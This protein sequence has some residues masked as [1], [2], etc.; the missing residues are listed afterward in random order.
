M[1]EVS[2]LNR[3][4]AALIDGVVGFG[5]GVLFGLLG[6]SMVDT[7]LSLVGLGYFLLK[8]ALFGGQSIGKKMMKYAAVKEDGSSLAGDYGAS[9]IRNVTL[10]VFDWVM[11]LL[12]KPRFGD[13]FAKTKVVNKA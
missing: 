13:T 12:D 11:V 6:L 2:K 4:L 8:D 9:A 10:L 7:I 3:F 5:P 1:T